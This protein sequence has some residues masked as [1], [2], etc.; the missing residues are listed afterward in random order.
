MVFSAFLEKYIFCLF[1]TFSGF[2][3]HYLFYWYEINFYR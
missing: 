3:K 1:T 2:Y